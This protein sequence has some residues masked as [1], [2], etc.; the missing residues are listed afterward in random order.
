MK[1]LF[2]IGLLAAFLFGALPP[3]L[4]DSP[5]EAATELVQRLHI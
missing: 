5:Q 4:A 2:G 3:A 1:T